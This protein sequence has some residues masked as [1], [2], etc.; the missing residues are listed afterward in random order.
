MTMK[1]KSFKIFVIMV[2]TANVGYAG[3]NPKIDEA[4]SRK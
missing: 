2:L 3:S 1:N 4:T